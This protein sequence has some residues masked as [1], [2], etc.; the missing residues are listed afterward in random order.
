MTERERK[1]YYLK[2]ILK[3]IMWKFCNKEDLEEEIR[4]ILWNNPKE[5]AEEFINKE[6]IPYLKNFGIILEMRS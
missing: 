2:R 5:W 3:V 1:D 6:V 4:I